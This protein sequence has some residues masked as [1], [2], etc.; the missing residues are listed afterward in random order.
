MKESAM[1]P[2]DTNTRKE[3]RRH[4]VPLIG[5]AAVVV[6]AFLAFLWWVSYAMQGPAATDAIEENPAPA[7]T[8]R[9]A[10]QN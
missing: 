2:H 4:A 8:G 1:S 6:V 7:E 5:M 3:A 10:P 9:T